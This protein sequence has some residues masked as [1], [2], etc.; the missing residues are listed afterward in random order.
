MVKNRR[1]SIDEVINKLAQIIVPIGARETFIGKIS[2][3]DV[4]R[5]DLAFS[6]LNGVIR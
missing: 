6:E 1:N 4:F 3:S 5:V 2:P